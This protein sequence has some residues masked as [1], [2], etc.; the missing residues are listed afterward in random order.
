MAA[1][2]RVDKEQDFAGWAFRT[3]STLEGTGAASQ[4]AGALL[5]L[6]APKELLQA[7]SFLALPGDAVLTVRSRKEVQFGAQ[8]IRD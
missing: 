6:M 2:S 4:L 3:P 8:M 5:R 7:E 1:I